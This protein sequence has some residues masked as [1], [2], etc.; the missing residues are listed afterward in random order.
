M[1]FMA[2]L[3][4]ALVV[5]V[6]LY[7]TII[8]PTDTPHGRRIFQ[9]AQKPTPFT[10]SGL[11]TGLYCA[12][13]LVVQ[14]NYLYHLF[15]SGKA[16]VAQAAKSVAT[17]FALNNLFLFSWVILWTRSLFGAATVF[18][19]A[20]YMNQTALY[21]HHPRLP[22]FV[23]LAVV[24]GP[25]A[26]SFLGLFWNI[27]LVVSVAGDPNALPVRVLG[28][29]A[30]WVVLVLGS[31]VVVNTTDYLL[32]YCLAWLSLCKSFSPS[33]LACCFL[34]SCLPRRSLSS[35]YPVPYAK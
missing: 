30:I 19:V 25:W 26:W 35:V 34:S 15:F 3:S 20:S 4:W 8:A 9:Q 22:A 12:T 24:A 18:L 23:H 16:C 10:Q 7:H 14:L 5:G 33:L 28:N 13:L 21:V 6:G 29:V 27:A 2:P 17:H 11:I 32:A 31:G 1:H